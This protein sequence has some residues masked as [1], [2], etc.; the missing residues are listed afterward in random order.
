MN[1]NGWLVLL[2]CGVISYGQLTMAVERFESERFMKK[3]GYLQ[4]KLH[5]VEEDMKTTMDNS[6]KE[7]KEA[8]GVEKLDPT[9]ETNVEETYDFST[10][11]IRR[12]AR[13]TEEEVQSVQA[14]EEGR[15]VSSCRQAPNKSGKYMI[16][17]GENTTPFEVLCEQ[18]TR[19]GG[20]WTVIQ[21]RFNGTVD[22]FRNWTE[23]RDGFGDLEGEFWLGL[24][25]LHLLTNNRP[26]ELLIEIKDFKCKTGYA[27][28]SEFEIGSETD[29]FKLTK[30][31]RYSGTAGNSMENNKGFKFTTFDR[32]NDNLE[33]PVNDD[34]PV[35]D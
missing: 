20:G 32:A 33:V 6:L 30:L 12:K 24:E 7:R 21:H 26:H 22:F 29:Q 27:R 8:S 35:K 31:G 28:Y 9:Y 10:K 2:F 34:L 15:Q 4:A 19:F 14:S 18:N 23:Y 17:I 16:Q 11:E 1:I 3:M 5:A 25:H 13:S